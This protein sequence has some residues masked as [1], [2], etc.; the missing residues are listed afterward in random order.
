MWNPESKQSTLEG[1]DFLRP[2]RYLFKKIIKYDVLMIP[3]MVIY[4]ILSAIYP[5]I[6]VVVPAKII[7]LSTEKVFSNILILLIIAGLLAVIARFM[8]SF[9]RG[10][11]RM[12]MNNVRYHLIRDLMKFSLNMPYENTLNA[13]T[14]DEL[15]LANDSVLNP[16]GGAGGIILTL[17]QIMGELLASIGFIGLFSTMSP[18]ILLFILIVVV[19]TFLL[20]GYITKREYDFWDKN[21]KEDRRIDTLLNF[22]KEPMNKKDIHVFNLYSLIQVYV[23]RYIE[24][25]NTLM[26]SL[27]K[28]RFRVETAIA[29]LDFLRDGVLYAWLIY[30]FLHNQINA[31]QFYLY[32][33]GIIAFV[34]IAQQC[35][36]DFTKIRTESTKFENYMKISVKGEGAA[37]EVGQHFVQK[38][39]NGVD[40][41]IREVS[42]R[43]PGSD[44]NVLSHFNL[45]VSPGEKLALV[46]E[47]GSGKSTLIKLLCRLYQPT[48]GEILVNQQ[49]IWGIPFEEYRKLLSVIFQDATILP[50]SIEENITM[51]VNADEADLKNAIEDSQLTDMIERLPKKLDT[52]LLRILDDE[53]VDLSG[54]QKQKLYLARALY[55]TESKILFL[56]EP[57]AA[58]DP[59]AERALYEQYGRIAEAKTSLFVSH[60]LASTQFCDHIAFLRDGSI[61]E[62]GTHRELIAQKGLY[63]ELFEIQAKNYRDSEREE[64]PA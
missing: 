55:K 6:W 5:F 11:Y 44:R 51:S 19:G 20:G 46:G 33:S 62:Y 63:Y 39:D 47:N 52:S 42:F 21:S 36:M 43:Y 14:L 64:V 30:Q 48:S 15:K 54:G 4:T 13:K 22:A 60:R 27:Y 2:V 45:H 38:Y 24:N 31:S 56:D 7:L 61:K 40:I 35:M 3:I 34:V 17:L 1:R 28:K 25:I 26:E 10:N 12:R 29:A 8:L 9:L 53:G 57:T 23:N 59:L 41:D 49:N 37:Q 18:F 50:F 58:L 16:Q 32:T